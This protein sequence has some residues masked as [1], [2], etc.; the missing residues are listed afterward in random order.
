MPI[1]MI[2]K[3]TRFE[4]TLAEARTMQNELKRAINETTDFEPE[5]VAGL[6]IDSDGRFG[7]DALFKFFDQYYEAQRR[8]RRAGAVFSYLLSRNLVTVYCDKCGQVSHQHNCNRPFAFN[9]I[10]INRMSALVDVRSILDNR[11]N[12]MAGI[13][14][15]KEQL[16]HDMTLLLN[17]LSV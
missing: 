6:H 8:D 3:G 4:F 14:D 7:R 15:R 13:G 5:T 17:H 12:V 1:I 16:R 11:A 2:I 10:P 9:G